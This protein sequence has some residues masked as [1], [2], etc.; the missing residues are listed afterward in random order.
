MALLQVDVMLQPSKRSPGCGGRRLAA[1]SESTRAKPP[2]I[3][4]QG[5]VLHSWHRA[6]PEP[7][8]PS[9]RAVA[10]RSPRFGTAIRPA[11]KKEIMR[12]SLGD[13]RLA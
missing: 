8:R 10:G 5:N 13:P 11:R 2:H 7:A 12:K 4:K 3:V 6:L 9:V 1:C